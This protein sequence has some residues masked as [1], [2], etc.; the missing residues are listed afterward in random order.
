MAQVQ[1]NEIVLEEL[2][3]L[4]EDNA[5]YKMSGP[6][7]IKLDLADAKMNVESR[8]KYFH[9]ELQRIENEAA[10]LTEQRDKQQQ[11][12]LDMANHIRKLTRQA[13]ESASKQPAITPESQ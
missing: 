10:K 1:E 3:L 4:K 9:Q 8:L 6:V 2:K 13:V 11:V 7:M 12:L 5:V